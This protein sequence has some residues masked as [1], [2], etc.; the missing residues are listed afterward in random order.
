MSTKE[1]I[2]EYVMDTPGNTNPAVLRSKLNELPEGSSLPDV[3]AADNGRVLGVVDGEW[4]KMSGIYQEFLIGVSTEDMSTFTVNTDAQAIV[5]AIEAKKQLKVRLWFSPFDRELARLTVGSIMCPESIGGV[6]TSYSLDTCPVKYRGSVVY[7]NIF[8]EK[9]DD[10]W[11]AT[12]SMQH[13]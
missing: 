1:E 5:N 8:L 4:A 10:T 9:S 6:V 2:F 12:A 13:L 7:A 11:T 3:T